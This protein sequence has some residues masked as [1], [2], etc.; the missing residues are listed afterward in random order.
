MSTVHSARNYL[1]PAIPNFL[2]SVLKLWRT[3]SGKRCYRV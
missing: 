2:F 1:V 3:L